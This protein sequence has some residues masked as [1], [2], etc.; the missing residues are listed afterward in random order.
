MSGVSGPGRWAWVDID[1]DAITH[2]VGVLSQA[3]A[4]AGVWAVVKADGYGHGALEVGSAAL[5]AGADGLCVALTAEGVSL[6][7]AGISAPILVLSEQPPGNA[8][9]IIEHHLTPTVSTPEGVDALGGRVE[10]AR[11]RA[12]R[13][14][15]QDRH[16]DAPGRGLAV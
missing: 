1:L 2:N 9:A 10:R 16:R 4:P 12:D 15:R 13:R 14:A 6:R 7:R 5:L 8:N 11:H 3:V